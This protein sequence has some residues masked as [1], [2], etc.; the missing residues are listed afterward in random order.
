MILSE[1]GYACHADEMRTRGDSKRTRIRSQR[2]RNERG[3][4]RN[5]G[6]YDISERALKSYLQSRT[7]ASRFMS[8]SPLAAP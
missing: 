5:T 1:K 4:V 6:R 7:I 2:R 3:K 8:G